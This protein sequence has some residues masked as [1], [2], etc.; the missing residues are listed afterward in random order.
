MEKFQVNKKIYVKY[1]NKTKIMDFYIYR[2]FVYIIGGG[3]DW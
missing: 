2:K 3:G 1:K